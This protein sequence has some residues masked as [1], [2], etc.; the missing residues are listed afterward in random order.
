MSSRITIFDHFARRL[1]EIEAPTTP[2]SW[3]LNDYGRCEF[4]LSTSDPKCIENNLQFGNLVFIEHL[5]SVDE[6]GNKHGKLP[7]WVGMIL[8][9]RSWDLGVCHV[10]A[11][12]AEAILAFRAMPYVSVKGTPKLV[13]EKILEHAGESAKNIIIQP[14]NLDDKSLTFPDDLRTNAYDHI[15]KLTNDA[16][17]DWDVVGDID[18][19]GNLSLYA[20]LYEKKGVDTTLVLHNGNTELNGPLLTEQGTP[21]NQVF[22]YSQAQTR[23]ARQRVEVLN[24][25]ALDD[26]GPLQLNQVFVGKHDI[27]SVQNAAQVRVNERGRPKKL[28]KRILLDHSDAF[29]MADIGN[30]MQVRDTNVGFYNGGFGVSE[31][32]RVISMDYNDLS[33]KV[34]LNIEVV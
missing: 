33:N 28:F 19:K 20:N 23:Q 30:R 3:V 17:M 6:T 26:Y 21:S 16:G 34:P 14:G 29:D 10:S 27:T 25:A 22:G 24:Q 15:K 31:T 13:F 9:P 7:D 12:A 2:R 18:S 32:V 11:Y 4:S 1:V 5:P 8:P